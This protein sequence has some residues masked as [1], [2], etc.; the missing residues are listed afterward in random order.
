MQTLTYGFPAHEQLRT[1]VHVGVVSSGDLEILMLP[2]DAEDLATVVVR[3]SV[4][5]FEKVWE[6]VLARFFESGAVKAR[7]EINDFG[8]T[9]GMVSLRLAQALE[10]AAEGT[11]E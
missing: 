11:S 1:P 7:Y 3:T 4:D 10:H 9:P 8:A 5:G 6:R 2:D